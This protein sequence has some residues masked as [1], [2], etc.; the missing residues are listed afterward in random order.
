[1][2]FDDKCGDC[3]T[4]VFAKRQRCPLK[5]NVVSRF[6]NSKEFSSFCGIRAF[7]EI[8]IDHILKYQISS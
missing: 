6:L 2:D 8:D 4:M 7:A 1:M 5:T 3:M